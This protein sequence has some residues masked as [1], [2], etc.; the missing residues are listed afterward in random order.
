MRDGCS[1]R[2]KVWE[3]LVSILAML[4]MLEWLQRWVFLLRVPRW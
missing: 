1:L 2:Q 3:R 4:I